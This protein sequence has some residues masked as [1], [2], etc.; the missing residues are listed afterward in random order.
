[1]IERYE[2]GISTGLVCKGI[3]LIE[4]VQFLSQKGVDV[5]ELCLGDEELT[6]DKIRELRLIKERTGLDYTVHTNSSFRPDKTPSHYNLPLYVFENWSSFRLADATKARW[7]V[8][9]PPITPDEYV[10]DHIIDSYLTLLG[11][12]SSQPVVFESGV[13]RRDSQDNVTDIE[14]GRNPSR[15]KRYLNHSVV[16]GIAGD[17]PKMSRSWEPYHPGHRSK[18]DIVNYI[19]QSRQFAIPIKEL[20]IVGTNFWPED[21]DF[22]KHTLSLL[23]QYGIIKVLLMIESVPEKLDLAISTIWDFISNKETV[24]EETRISNYVSR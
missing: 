23:R 10:P 6:Q 2:I 1:M 20:H 21:L 9:H 8:Q 14:D 4:A 11:S 17:V 18:Q 13:Y 12:I 16:L 3:P 5:I 19:D 24:S 7:I 22:A 15:L